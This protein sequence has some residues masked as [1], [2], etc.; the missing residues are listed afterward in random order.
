MKQSQSVASKLLLV[1][2]IIMAIV[3]VLLLCLPTSKATD[4]YASQLRNRYNEIL[5]KYKDPKNN[6][7]PTAGP[8]FSVYVPFINLISITVRNRSASWLLNA[9]VKDVKQNEELVPFED[10]L[11]PVSQEQLRFVL[12]EGEPGIGKSTLAKELALRWAKQSD[13]LLNQYVTVIL[14]QLRFETYH[15]TKRI[16]D[17]FIE[18]EDINMTELKLAIK[19]RKGEGILWILDGFDELPYHLRSNSIFIQLI[20]GDILPKSTVIVTSRPVAS[21]PLLTFLYKHDSKRISI[22]GF[23][24][25]K[26]LEYA[27]KY[28]DNSQ[29]FS[30]FQA[31]YSGNLVIES[32]LYNPLNCYI[33]CTIFN[34]FILMDN[35]QYPRTMT[36]LYNHYVH[37]LLKRHLL[38]VGIITDIDYNMPKKMI[39]EIDFKNSGLGNIWK[40]F[41]LLSKIAYDGVMKQ[42]YIFGKELHNVTKLSMM[43]TI[44][45]HFAFNKDESSS[46]LHTTLQ[47]YLAAIYLANNFIVRDD[48]SHQ[49][50]KVVLTFYVGILKMIDRKLDPAALDILKKNMTVDEIDKKVHIGSLLIDCLYED[51][52]L[53][54][55][56][57][58]LLNQY[59]SAHSDF[60]T[61]FQFYI[62]GYLVAVQNITYDASFFHLNQLKAFHKGLRSHSIIN[63]KL[64]IA[65]FFSTDERHTKSALKELL[66]MANHVI[67]ALKIPSSP[68]YLDDPAIFCNIISNSQSLQELTLHIDSLSCNST[69]KNPLLKLKKLHK[70]TLQINFPHEN[71]FKT[72]RELTAPRRPLKKLDIK[73]VSLELNYTKILNLIRKKSSLEELRII[74]DGAY[75]VAGS[76]TQS[77]EQ[78][79]LQ[80]IEWHKITNDLRIVFYQHFIYH[81]GTNK[82]KLTTRLSSFT[83]FIYIRIKKEWFHAKITIYSKSVIPKL[84]RFISAFNQC[85]LLLKKS[86]NN[87]LFHLSSF[88]YATVCKKPL[89]YQH[90][91]NV[92]KMELNLIYDFIK[93]IT[94]IGVLKALFIQVITSIFISSI[95]INAYISYKIT[96]KIF[97]LCQQLC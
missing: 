40:N 63:G 84:G 51:D 79:N 65:L 73:V 62:F 24:S 97:E 76:S 52:S 47:E 30:E 39:R 5:T 36:A 50:L 28:F 92:C 31:Y 69:S 60:I 56:M 46:F 1:V 59:V 6:K 85:S 22:R 14:I 45:N 27:S 16:E 20:S 86:P 21:D 18:F 38:D 7:F 10:I 67:I 44:V 83:S 74:G 49:N 33:V 3:L 96:Y 23:D 93:F 75:I 43:D 80:E 25:D 9:T 53:I 90:T 71:V 11:K 88:M 55:K 8:L 4:M 48:R 89:N 82:A 64:K 19:K 17:L 54:Y 37:V 26:T 57:G 94:S 70:L 15:K 2:V 68:Y 95:Q 13:K 66:N 35:K 72:L 58:Y 87:D 12:M 78:T 41:S 34:D 32:M 77:P 42:K 81:L 29:V 91:N 61:D